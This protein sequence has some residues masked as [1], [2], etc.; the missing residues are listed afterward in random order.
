MY[1]DDSLGDNTTPVYRKIIAP[2]VGGGLRV[3]VEHQPRP[4]CELTGRDLLDTADICRIFGCSIRTVYRWI[5]EHG[6]R[7]RGK[8]GRELLFTKADLLRW[9]AA[10]QPRPGRPSMKRR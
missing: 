4:F 9:Y 7:P 8:A 3:Y 6:L 5:N 2:A 1:V 10:N